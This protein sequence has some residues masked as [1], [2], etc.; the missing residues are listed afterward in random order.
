MAKWTSPMLKKDDSFLGKEAIWSIPV[1][2]PDLGWSTPVLC[3]RGLL[4]W[5]DVPPDASRLWVELS[6]SP[7][8]DAYQVVSVSLPCNASVI[9]EKGRR[10]AGLHCWMTE[11]ISNFLAEHGDC[12]LRVLYRKGGG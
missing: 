7:D 2:K 8:P 12:Y 1:R 10:R 11:Q 5:F 6:E 3:T 9:T 4:K